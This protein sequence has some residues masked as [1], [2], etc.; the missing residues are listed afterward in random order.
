MHV[1]KDDTVLILT[2]NER[3]KRGRVLKVFPGKNS[4]IVEGVRFIKRHQKPSAKN[5]SGGIIQKEA[6]IQAANV[7]VVCSKCGEP[8]RVKRREITEDGK[9]RHT[10]ACV[11][12]GEVF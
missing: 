9:T 1:R 3:G 11:K 2:G 8:T 7:M 6:P 5:T 12:C 10:R 4:L